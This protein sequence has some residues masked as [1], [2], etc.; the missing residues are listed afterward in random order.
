MAEMPSTTNVA[1]L[2]DS[3]NNSNR[4][5]L[6]SVN[7]ELEIKIWFSAYSA[8]TLPVFTHHKCERL[9]SDSLD[10]M[11]HIILPLTINNIEINR[12]TA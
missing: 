3:S 10:K 1:S 7:V 12:C 2:A 6:K 4:S 11:N 5:Q 8:A 9:N